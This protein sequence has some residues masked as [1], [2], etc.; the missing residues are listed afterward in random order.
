M[1]KIRFL[2]LVII[3]VVSILILGNGCRDTH[4]TL[5][6]FPIEVGNSWEYSRK[7][8]VVVYDTVN[9]DTTEF[10]VTDSLHEEFEG[11]DTLAGWECYRLKRILYE[12]NGMYSGTWWYAHPDTALLCIAYIY[13]SA[14]TTTSPETDVHLGFRLGGITF[15]SPQ[16]LAQYLYYQRNCRLPT[17]NLLNSDT[18]YWSSPK[19]VFIYPLKVGVSWTAIADT[20]Q[21][22]EEREVMAEDSVTVPAGT[23]LALRIERMIDW[24][25]ENDFLCMWI[26][27]EGIVKDSCRIRGEVIDSGGSVIGY[28]VGDD[29]YEL[30]DFHQ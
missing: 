22:V 16:A 28:L 26:S 27:E 3:A 5:D 25:T 10:L 12:Q 18:M 4:K 19:K 2:L 14:A 23:F 29:I 20:N 21:W 9:N 1:H 15:D 7:F 24:M 8:S 6:H 13:Y 11:I 30:L 17:L